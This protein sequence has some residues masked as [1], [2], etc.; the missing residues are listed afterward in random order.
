MLNATNNVSKC[1]Y[2]EYSQLYLSLYYTYF[3]FVCFFLISSLK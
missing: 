2:L 3:Q 1:I